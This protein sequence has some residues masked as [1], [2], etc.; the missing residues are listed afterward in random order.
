[1]SLECYRSRLRAFEAAAA[2]RAVSAEISGAGQAVLV[3]LG[4]RV[5][6]AAG[7]VVALEE[8]G[9]L[10]FGLQ[11]TALRSTRGG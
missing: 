11:G 7:V 10:F 1:M 9:C 2:E 8:Y 6:P 5:H 4:V 3:R